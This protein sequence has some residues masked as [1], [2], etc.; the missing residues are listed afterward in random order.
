MTGLSGLLNLVEGAI[1]S[2]LAF[3]NLII[4][5]VRGIFSL[6]SFAP[7]A[8]KYLNAFIGYAPAFLSV[9]IVAGL[10]ILIVRFIVD[11]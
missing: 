6:V 9:F 3:F 4:N 11:R 10:S 1:G 5:L 2:L 7:S 8:L